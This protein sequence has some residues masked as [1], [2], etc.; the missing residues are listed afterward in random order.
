MNGMEEE[1]ETGRENHQGIMVARSDRAADQNTV[2]VAVEQRILGKPAALRERTASFAPWIIQL[3]WLA[4]G[5]ATVA[6]LKSHEW[7]TF[8]AIPLMVA[9]AFGLTAW[10]GWTIAWAMLARQSVIHR[11]LYLLAGALAILAIAEGIFEW[12]QQAKQIPV[13]IPVMLGVLSIG[14][15]VPMALVYWRGWRID[16][17][18]DKPPE[19]FH[20][21]R[22]GRQFSISEL[23]LLTTGA[24]VF[25][26]LVL[27][28]RIPWGD[29][30]A[31]CLI[32]ACGTMLLVVGLA[33]R[34]FVLATLVCV[35]ISLATIVATIA[36]FD[37]VAPSRPRDWLLLGLI[38]APAFIGLLT[39]IGL[40]RW[41]GYRLMPNSPAGG[42]G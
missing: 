28:Q 12:W 8:G 35:L 38:F 31:E 17:P 13:Q 3:L 26:G 39:S 19:D 34:R 33:A 9:T 40:A 42:G 30:V 27:E 5:F 10:L 18:G 2:E 16:A 14:F 32:V 37:G 21:K 41:W 20:A 36:W 15:A 1:L 24:A 11:V 6:Y 25:L 22:R 29:I 7:G 4:A 23:L